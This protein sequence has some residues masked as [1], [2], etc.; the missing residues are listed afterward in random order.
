M[1]QLSVA[2]GANA[3]AAT[4]PAASLHC[5]V[6][7][8]A[9]AKVVHVGA[10]LSTILVVAGDSVQAAMIPAVPAKVPPQAALVTYLVFIL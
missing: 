10:V 8:K 4:K 2:A 1:P 9:P 5:S 7:S 3:C 6:T